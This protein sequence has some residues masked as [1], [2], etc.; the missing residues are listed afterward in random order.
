MLLYG[1]LSIAVE[2]CQLLPIRAIRN[3]HHVI[4]RCYFK[5]YFEKKKTLFLETLCTLHLSRQEKQ[6]NT[7]SHY[8]A[9]L[10]IATILLKLWDNVAL[11][12]SYNNIILFVYV[13]TA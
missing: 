12:I 8:L 13:T 1:Y 2:W 6:K 4:L 10:Q 5:C 3:I 7:S 11:R 9:Y